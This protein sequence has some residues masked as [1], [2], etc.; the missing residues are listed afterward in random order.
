MDEERVSLF[1]IFCGLNALGANE[2]GRT[3]KG[4]RINL[5][6]KPGTAEMSGAN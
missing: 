3:E 1:F 5:N 6:P 4:G 2:E